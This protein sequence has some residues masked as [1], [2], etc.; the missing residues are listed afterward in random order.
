MNSAHRGGLFYGVY[1]VKNKYVFKNKLAKIDVYRCMWRNWSRVS[2]P[3]NRCRWNF[4]DLLGLF[5]QHRGSAVLLQKQSH[6][7]RQFPFVTVTSC[8]VYLKNLKTEMDIC[9]E[10]CTLFLV[11]CEFTHSFINV[12]MTSFNCMHA[13]FSQIFSLNMTSLTDR[14]YL[15]LGGDFLELGRTS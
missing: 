11:A 7:T 13:S 10:E 6:E 15:T 1:D 5:S 3:C 4:Q 14:V 2:I 9:V 8:S 12:L